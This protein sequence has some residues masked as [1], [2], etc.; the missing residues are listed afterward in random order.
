MGARINALSVLAALT[1]VAATAQPYRVARVMSTDFLAQLV[2]QGLKPSQVAIINASV[3]SAMIIGGDAAGSLV[4]IRGAG[5]FVWSQIAE[6]LSESIAQ[7]EPMHLAI[8]HRSI[9][10]AA[11]PAMTERITAFLVQLNAFDVDPSGRP[12]ANA[13]QEIILDATSF[14]IISSGHDAVVTI[15]P[16]GS[17]DPPLQRA[18]GELHSVVSR[19]A[20]SVLL[21]VQQHD[22]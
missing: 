16:N 8:A 20:G 12:P 17:L 6:Q 21:Q 22:F 2:Q 13:L 3:G 18:A 1:A 15:K 11:C 14:L 4:Y 10:V 5:S 7:Q 9:D 19:C